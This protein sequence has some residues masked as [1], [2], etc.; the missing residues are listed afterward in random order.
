MIWPLESLKTRWNLFLGLL[1]PFLFVALLLKSWSWKQCLLALILSKVP[2][3]TTKSALTV[4]Q[5]ISMFSLLSNLHHNIPILYCLSLSTY[6]ISSLRQGPH[7]FFSQLY[8]QPLTQYLAHS[9]HSKNEKGSD[10]K[11]L[12]PLTA[13]DQARRLITTFNTLRTEKSTTPWVLCLNHWS[14]WNVCICVG[15]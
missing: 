3:I 5:S 4:S 9:R 11:V 6:T 7:Q 2:C 15:W 13:P 8:P 14:L 10:T 12:A 1:F